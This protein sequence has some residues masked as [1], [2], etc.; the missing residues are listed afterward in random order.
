MNPGEAVA[1]ART[2]WDGML[3]AI[4]YPDDDQTIDLIANFQAPA[5]RDQLMADIPGIDEPMDRVLLAQTDGGPQW[6]RGQ[7]FTILRMGIT[8]LT[9]LTGSATTPSL[10]FAQMR[11]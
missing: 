11:N 2:L 3:E 1:Q 8:N 9:T 6:S 5:I 7:R 10:V 4:S